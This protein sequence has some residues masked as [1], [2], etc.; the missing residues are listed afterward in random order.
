MSLIDA[1]RLHISGGT[2][3]QVAGH[4][5]EYYVAGDLVQPQGEN[6]ITILQRHICGD[7]FY[8]SEQRFPPPQC[9][10]NTRTEVQ[11]TV[12]SWADEPHEAPSVM[13]LYGPAGAGKSAIA[14]TMAERWAES[15][16]LAA[17]FF[18]ARWRVGGSAGKTLFPTIAYQLALH[19]PQLRASIGRAVEE[20]PAICDKSLEE[21]AAVLIVQPMSGLRTEVDNPYLVVV[22]GLDEC[23]GKPVQSRIIKTIFRMC[24]NDNLPLR[25][26]I[27]SRP[28]PHIRETFESLKEKAKFRYVV[29]DDTFQPS[30]D[31][32]RYLRDRFT[33]IQR[34]RFPDDFST[35]PLWLAE[36]DLEQLV[37]NASGQFI[38]AATVIK[39]VDDEYSHPAEQL[40][41]VLG[42]SAVQSII[43]PF[44][45]LD[46]LYTF[47]LSTNPNVWLMV[48]ILGA[49]FS[50][51]DPEYT[52]THC[53]AFLD[54]IL[55][56]ER[57]TV[58]FALRGLHS[59]LFIPDSDGSRIRVHHASLHDFLSNPQRAGVYYLAKDAHH[60]DLAQRCLSV[61][62]HSI[63]QPHPSNALFTYAHKQW[64]N[65]YIPTFE[66]HIN[67]QTCLQAFRTVL[68][69]QRLSSLCCDLNAT[70]RIFSCLIEFLKNLA[71]TPFALQFSTWDYETTW[72][73]LLA[74][75]FNS[76]KDLIEF[77][78]TWTSDPLRVDCI[79]SPL[80]IIFQGLGSTDGASLSNYNP[81][82]P[83]PLGSV[84]H[85]R[86]QIA[87][88]LHLNP[89]PQIRCTIAE[90]TLCLFIYRSA[91][92]RAQDSYSPQRIEGLFKKTFSPF[93]RNDFQRTVT[94]WFFA[95]QWCFYL[96]QAP[97]APKLLSLLHRVIESGVFIR[98]D[99]IQDDSLYRWLLECRTD[100]AMEVA[101]VIRKVR[102]QASSMKDQ[103]CRWIYADFSQVR[104]C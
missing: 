66:Q 87:H 29:L 80:G 88:F 67:I 68:E 33:E 51:P 61:I 11:N 19:I 15:E 24:A 28:E 92:L 76:D 63:E 65:H 77:F 69:P 2:F 30:R 18:F 31:I 22:D 48:R 99:E 38:Y 7:A 40:R 82:G 101:E 14:Q 98:T 62:L 74:R 53:A 94:H 37:N 6:G 96:V 27:C 45:D 39:F 10:P 20:D 90:T 60:M 58:R 25:F 78:N 81:K 55:G 42:L 36:E 73:T 26:F 89:A 57:G 50:I 9:H 54:N 32:K 95:T 104:W 52:T 34:K 5:K 91:E 70:T 85:F 35:Y 103:P 83:V 84:Q 102:E 93:W 86:Q 3:S 56:L 8:N 17:A 16:D 75:L 41:L 59:I 44:G 12:Q 49:F 72:S 23:E 100:S 97:H 46:A 79:V 64:K 1:Y 43:S 47:I 4:H 71:N 13:W 21:Q